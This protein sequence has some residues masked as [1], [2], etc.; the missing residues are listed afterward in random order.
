MEE[1]KRKAFPPTANPTQHE[2]GGLLTQDVPQ[3][4]I[5]ETFQCPETNHVMAAGVLL[6]MLLAAVF[7][8]CFISD[9]QV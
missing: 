3:P 5:P 8:L 1:S 9:R 4:S 7:S 6:F 2:V